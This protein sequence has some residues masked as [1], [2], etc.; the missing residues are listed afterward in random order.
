MAVCAGHLRN[1]MLA[2]Y[3]QIAA[4]AVWHAPFYFATGLGHQA[5]M[6][7]FV[8]SGFFVGGSVLRNPER[9]S[10]T[11][12]AI[13]RLSRLWTVLVPALLLTWAVDQVTGTSAPAAL[14]GAYR[15][16]WHS[17]PPRDGYSAD[18]MTFGGNLL[19]LQTI[20]VRVF[21]SNEPLWSLANEFWYYVLFPCAMCVTGFFPGFRGARARLIAGVALIA[22][23]AFLPRDFYPG[24][25]IWLLGVA[26]YLWVRSRGEKPQLQIP[27][28]L[29][30]LAA[31]VFS[32]WRAKTAQGNT[33]L[34]DVFVGG[35]FALFGG[36]LLAV[37]FPRGNL[38]WLA[39]ASRG[40]A[41]F[42]YSLYLFHF[43]LVVLLAATFYRGGKL[44]PDGPALAQYLGWLVCLFA[45]AG[46]FWFLF[47]R[48][49]GSIRRAVRNFYRPTPP[50]GGNGL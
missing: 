13:A 46:A 33:H 1:A 36:W 37:P 34:N 14:L 22:T 42:S 8:L 31:F 26:L 35:T 41:A 29:L 40:S 44:Q 25:L 23:G 49:T 24:L 27:L 18:W 43:P 3:G 9:F 39:A 48:N 28:V 45:G 12:Y 20:T 21:G 5:V 30:G 6:V 11:D 7:F 19:F 38:G 4:P 2:D 16:M 50:P 17:G 32:I 47:E 10:S 15:E